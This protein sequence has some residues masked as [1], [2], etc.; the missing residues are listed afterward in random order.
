M[1][2][3]IRYEGENRERTEAEE[4]AR[5]VGEKSGY[6][7]G[8]NIPLQF[9]GMQWHLLLLQSYH[10]TSHHTTKDLAAETKHPATLPLASTASA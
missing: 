6:L 5:E 10:I 1:V 3:A 9:D 8:I 2:R 7:N 4:W